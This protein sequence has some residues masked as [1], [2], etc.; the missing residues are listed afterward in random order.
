[1]KNTFRILGLALMIASIGSLTSCDKDELESGLGH[2]VNTVTGGD[3]STAPNGVKIK[4]LTLYSWPEKD[5]NGSN[6]DT[7]IFGGSEPDIYVAIYDMLTS[8]YK[9]GTT[10]DCNT[11]RHYSPNIQLNDLNKT[12]TIKVYD[13]DGLDNDDLMAGISWKPSTQNS[14]YASVYTLSNGD[15]KIGLEL[16]WLY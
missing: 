10:E 14:N 15:T 9:S 4:E 16:T 12:Y 13:E 11:T 8:L 6:W 3:E 5:P 7:G 1:M 2:L